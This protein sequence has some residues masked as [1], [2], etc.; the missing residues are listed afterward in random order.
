MD[1]GLGSTVGTLVGVNVGNELG[2]TVI[3]VV[4]IRLGSVVGKLVCVTVG[5]GLG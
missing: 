5:H 1:A 2:W 3:G 4:G